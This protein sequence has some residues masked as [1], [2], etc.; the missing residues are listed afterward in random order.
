MWDNDNFKI[1]LDMFYDYLME[2]LEI[3][4]EAVPCSKKRSG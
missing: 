3:C 2:I 4:R 1:N